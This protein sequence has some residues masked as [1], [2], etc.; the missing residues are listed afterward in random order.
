MVGGPIV[1]CVLSE[2]IV[3]GV[4]GCGLAASTFVFNWN[5]G[6]HEKEESM[7]VKKT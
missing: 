3:S 6:R 4:K 1:S 2:V 5:E 7:V